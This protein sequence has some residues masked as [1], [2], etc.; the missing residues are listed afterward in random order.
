M[1]TAI[2]L[3][4]AGEIKTPE[5]CYTYTNETIYYTNEEC[6]YS[7][8]EALKQNAF[9]YYDPSTNEIHRVVDV[10]CVNWGAERV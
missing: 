10:Y 1:F 7:I 5:T 2:V 4:C 8:G 9:E 3:V 6:V